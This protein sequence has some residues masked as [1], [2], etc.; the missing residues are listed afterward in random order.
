[1]CLHHPAVRMQLRLPLCEEDFGL[2]AT[3]VVPD[4]NAVEY[5]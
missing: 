5:L 4:S 2:N 1:M 3:G